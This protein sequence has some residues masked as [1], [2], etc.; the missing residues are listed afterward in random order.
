LIR[1][2][3]TK[4]IAKEM[5]KDNLV[6]GLLHVRDGKDQ[7]PDHGPLLNNEK[8]PEIVG[9]VLIYNVEFNGHLGF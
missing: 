3:I 4:E 8:E 6:F 1:T 7:I 9:D 2:K 5:A